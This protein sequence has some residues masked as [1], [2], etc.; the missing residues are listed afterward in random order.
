METLKK[1]IENKLFS[2][3]FSTL[4]EKEEIKISEDIELK[5][6]FLYPENFKIYLNNEKLLEVVFY[7]NKNLV[8]INLNLNIINNL[9]IVNFKKNKIELK[10]NNKEKMYLHTAILVS[11]ILKAIFSSLFLF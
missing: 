2:L 9:S 5:A 8:E 4:S 11:R 7:I 6:L 1:W 3:F 10:F